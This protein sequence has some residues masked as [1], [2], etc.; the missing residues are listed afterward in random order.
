MLL[1]NLLYVGPRV[2][3]AL[4]RLVQ[5]WNMCWLSTLILYLPVDGPYDSTPKPHACDKAVLKVLMQ[6]ERLQEGSAEHQKG[7]SVAPP[8][9]NIWLFGEANQHPANWQNITTVL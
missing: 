8:R 5:N 9:W 2:R 3:P 7:Q 1:L 6:D 4:T